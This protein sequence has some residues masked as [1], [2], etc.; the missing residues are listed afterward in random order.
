LGINQGTPLYSLDVT[1][2]GRFLT[3][4]A[5]SLLVIGDNAASSYSALQLNAGSGHKN[6]IMGTQYNIS[7]AWELTPST[8]NGG[9]TFS[10]PALQIASTGA[11]TFSSSISATS[12]SFSAQGTSG[13]V[14][15]ISLADAGYQTIAI[16]STT[17]TNAGGI[18]ITNTG[19]N[20]YF[21]LDSS[22]GGSYGAGAY[23]TVVAGAGANPITML[24]NSGAVK[25]LILNGTT[26]AATFSS[27]VYANTTG[28][29]SD[30]NAGS[31]IA[32]ASGSTTKYTQIGFDATNTYGWIQ[33]LEQGVA[34]RNLILNGAGGNVG[35]GTTS[36]G[37]NLTVYGTGTL[38]T[39]F[40]QWI[41][42][43]GTQRLM[44]GANTTAAEVQ[45]AGSIPLYIN[46]GGNRTV[47]NGS[48]VDNVLIGTTTDTGQKLQ[49]NGT[50]L[51]AATGGNIRVSGTTDGGLF[52]SGSLIYLSD[53]NTATKGLYVSLTTGVT[54]IQTLG[55]GTVTASSGTLSATSDMN[56]KISDGYIDTALDKILKLVPRYFYWKEETGLP[57]DIRQLGFYAQEV[58]AALGEEAAN[59]PKNENDKWGIYDRGIIAMLTKAIQEQQIQIQNLQEQINILAK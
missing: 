6:W 38:A 55:T 17:G 44:L 7:D 13:N 3:S 5:K 50:I 36:P 4:G 37:Q 49:V 16:T 45:S 10:T 34:Y 51:A 27:K 48:G 18:K 31:F 28:L 9:S 40:Q 57:T 39:T 59:T 53:W 43:N 2:T 29:N 21:G 11:A 56:L 42:V 24:V 12:A 52:T 14:I 35:I 22:T 30:F 41:T 32:Y 26:G 15:N 54:T 46:Y 33:A 47:I 23:N 19:G 8:T 25:A 1:G 20:A 58:N